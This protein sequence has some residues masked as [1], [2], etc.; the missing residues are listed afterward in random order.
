MSAPPSVPGAIDTPCTGWSRS[1]SVTPSTSTRSREGP[2]TAGET[3]R[4][5]A[6]RATRLMRG[7]CADN[8]R[9]RDCGQFRNHD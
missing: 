9:T 5:R 6:G 2:T 8:V 7:G 3:T 4:I 1:T